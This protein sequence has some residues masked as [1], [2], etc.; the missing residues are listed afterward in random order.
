M[1]KGGVT[2]VARRCDEKR[3]GLVK[4]AGGNVAGAAGRQGKGAPEREV[5]DV[6]AIAQ[7]V[8]TI[9]V[10]G[11]FEGMDQERGAARTAE[12]L[13][14]VQVGLGCDAGSD[15]ATPSVQVWQ[16]TKQKHLVFIKQ[17]GGVQD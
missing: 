10:D 9:G 6:E 13:Q 15:A 2:V 16:A 5:D 11:P 3:A 12:D 17:S 8:V 1:R 14:R 4:I 7:V